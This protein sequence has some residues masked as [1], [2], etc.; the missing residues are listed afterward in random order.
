MSLGDVVDKLLNQHSLSDTS[1]SEETNLSTTS[2]GGEEV[3]NLDTG[4]ENLSSGGLLNECGGLGVDGA[5]LVANNGATLVNGLANDVHDTAESGLSDGNHDGGTGVDNL[6]TTDETLSTVHG[7]GTDGVL[8]EMGGDLEDETTAGEVLDF[9]GVQ[10]GGKA[11]AVE[12]N[13]DDGTNDGLD[14]SNIGLGLGGIG[15]SDWTKNEAVCARKSGKTHLGK[16]S[17]RRVAVAGEQRLRPWGATT[18]QQQRWRRTRWSF[19]RS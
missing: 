8:A 1:T 16:K 5:E 6:G 13:V 7:N 18:S 17:E 11:V 2:V 10:D 19:V 9:E 14:T 3:D 15:A 4:L 12:L